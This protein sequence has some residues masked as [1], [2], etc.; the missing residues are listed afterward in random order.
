MTK[1]QRDEI[2]SI[3][4]RLRIDHK[5]TYVQIADAIAA[6]KGHRLDPSQIGHYIRQVHK[7]TIANLRDEAEAEKLEQTAI[8]DSMLSEAMAAWE[9][10]KRRQY[11][12]RK[13]T[14]TGGGG[15][16]G[17]GGPLV[18]RLTE[19]TETPGDPR[20]LKEAREILKA[21]RDIWGLG[22]NH[23]AYDGELKIV[24]EYEEFPVG[25]GESGDGSPD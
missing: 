17:E 9:R 21:K 8:L 6:E 3:A 14:V 18:E 20:F 4:W 24:V 13:K 15:E 1:E 12:R 19:Y 11:K 25:G 23:D 7:R 22:Q 5:W 10:S 2:K 16:G